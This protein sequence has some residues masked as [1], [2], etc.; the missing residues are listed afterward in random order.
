M[1]KVL[2]GGFPYLF[3]MT[4]IVGSIWRYRSNKYTWS[5]QSSQ[6]VENKTLFFG[7]FPWHYGIIVLLLGHI[8]GLFIPRAILLWN[9]VPARLYILELTALSAGFL[10]LFGLLAFIYRRITN[11]RVK[12]LTSGWDV[13]L[14][15]I[16]LIQVVTGL[17]NAIAYRWGSNWYAG[18]AVPW[19]WSVF[20]LNPNVDYVANLP[21]I[22]KVHIFNAMIFIGLIPFSRRV[23]FIVINPYKYLVRP[24]QVVR[25][26]NRNPRTENIVQYK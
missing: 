16:L 1:D 9:S 7:S 8:L 12:S 3:I 26:Y 13:L 5:T 14:L 11:S 6:F 10:A 20:S 25:W 21:L 19:M 23:H 22:T 18:A 2:F 24:Y 15:I 4:A 17:G